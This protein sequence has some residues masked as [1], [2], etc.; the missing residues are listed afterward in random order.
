M[1]DTYPELLLTLR[2]HET[3]LL[4]L[5]ALLLEA[6]ADLRLLA[7]DLLLLLLCFLRTVSRS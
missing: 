3:L 1:A 6:L 4:L 5:S 7:V 2:G